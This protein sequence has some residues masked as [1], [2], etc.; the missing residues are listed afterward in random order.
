M[1][2]F[3]VTLYQRNEIGFF[4]VGSLDK[5]KNTINYINNCGNNKYQKK[6]KQKLLTCINMV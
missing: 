3:K 2:E 5:P 4:D 1:L 6:F